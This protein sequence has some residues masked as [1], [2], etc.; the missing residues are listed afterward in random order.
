MARLACAGALGALSVLYRGARGQTVSGDTRSDL[1]AA[2]LRV[3]ADAVEDGCVRNLPGAVHVTPGDSLSPRK[4]ELLLRA[5][6]H[7]TRRRGASGIEVRGLLLSRP[8]VVH[9]TD[10]IAAALVRGGR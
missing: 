7:P 3:L 4:V 8:V 2:A 9:T 6:D 10:Q 1:I 5:L